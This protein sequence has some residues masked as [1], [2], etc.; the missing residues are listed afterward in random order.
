MTFEHV[1][2]AIEVEWS[3]DAGFL[4]SLR[5][6]IFDDGKFQRLL[7]LLRTIEIAEGAHVPIR[8]VSL[9]WYIPTFMQWQDERLRERGQDLDAYRKAMARVVN[10]LERILGTP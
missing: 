7:A 2:E 8:L 10:E 1:V 3:P 5:Q 6:G 9:L 4:W